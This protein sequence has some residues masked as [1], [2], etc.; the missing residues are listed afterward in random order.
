M[1][2]RSPVRALAALILAGASAAPALAQLTRSQAVPR[3][4][5]LDYVDST[6]AIATLLLDGGTIEHE[7]ADVNGDG[8]PDIASV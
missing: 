6:G 7:M 3:G 4:H 1:Y 2:R 5:V 8:C